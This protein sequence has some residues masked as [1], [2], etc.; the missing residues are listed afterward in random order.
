[1]RDPTYNYEP[2]YN[3]IGV[4]R[5][6]VRNPRGTTSANQAL[7]NRNTYISH[8][9]PIRRITHMLPRSKFTYKK[10]PRSKVGQCKKASY[11]IMLSDHSG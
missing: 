11:T 10:A 2:D 9:Q 3:M 7:K 4:T 5:Q 6:T 8:V 1:V